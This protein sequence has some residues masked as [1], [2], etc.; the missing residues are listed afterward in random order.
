MRPRD[1]KHGE[2]V[3]M[4]KTFENLLK[5]IDNT[6]KHDYKRVLEKYPNDRRVR[7]VSLEQMRVIVAR[8]KGRIDRKKWAKTIGLHADSRH[9]EN[10]IAAGP[11]ESKNQVRCSE[12]MYSPK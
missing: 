2:Y 4:D 9:Q 7:G 12:P 3:A 1:P 6:S 10:T 11:H 8:Q 5:L